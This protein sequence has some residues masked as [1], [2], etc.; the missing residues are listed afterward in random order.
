LNYNNNVL[1]KFS[2]YGHDLKYYLAQGK[3]YSSAPVDVVVNQALAFER[4]YY[5]SSLVNDW[6]G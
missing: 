6:D 1:A 4:Y 5:P 2:E 3:M